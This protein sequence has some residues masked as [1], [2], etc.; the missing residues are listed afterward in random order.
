M[1]NVLTFSNTNEAI[2]NFYV[3]QN[4]NESKH[5]F[6][7]NQEVHPDCSDK[8]VSIQTGAILSEVFKQIGEFEWEVLRQGKSRRGL[9]HTKAHIVAVY[10]NPSDA[11]LKSYGKFALYII[12]SSDRSRKL[13]VSYGWLNGACLNGCIFGEL[14]LEKLTQRHYGEKAQ[15]IAIQVQE[16]VANIK[17]ILDSGLS[18]ELSMIKRMIQTSIT[19]EEFIEFAKKAVELR[20]KYSSLKKLDTSAG[21]SFKLNETELEKVM[22]SS[23]PEFGNINLW[24]AYQIVHENLGGN[25]DNLPSRAS[26]KV[27]LPKI[28]LIVNRQ[29]DNVLVSRKATIRKFNDIDSKVNFNTDLISLMSAPIN[30]SMQLAA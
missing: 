10:F 14:V 5:S 16:T 2:K 3:N 25:F 12:N 11:V 6:V 27:E 8:Y 4:F 13:T 28:S 29:K 30:Q 23:R 9:Q 26:K 15:N 19:K 18:N 7:F 1:T 21:E 22:N 24:N 20:L 17:A